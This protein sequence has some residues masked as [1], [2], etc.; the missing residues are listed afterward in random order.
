[1]ENFNRIMVTEQNIFAVPKDWLI[2]RYE[3]LQKKIKTSKDANQVFDFK[4]EVGIIDGFFE[5]NKEPQNLS[6]VDQDEVRIPK[7]LKS[8]YV[9]IVEARLDTHYQRMIRKTELGRDIKY[10]SEFRAAMPKITASYNLS[11]GGSAGEYQ[12]S[13]EQAVLK[14]FDRYERLQQE[15]YDLE[16]DMYMMSSVV[17]P[18]L[19]SEQRELIE[20]RYFTKE[21]VTDNLVMDVLC[22]HRAK[23]Y[24]IKKATLLK[25]ASEL[26]LI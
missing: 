1:M 24:R 20:K 23:Y 8:Q 18:K 17:I 7:P 5:S 3:H 19:D 22:W 4:R 26:K 9:P 25:I 10:A 11:S 14:P 15:L 21:R 6:E 16:E 2:I 12:S 13:T